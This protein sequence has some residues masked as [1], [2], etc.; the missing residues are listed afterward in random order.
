MRLGTVLTATDLNPLYCDFIPYFVDSW[1]VLFPEIDVV[2]VLVAD[3]IPDK[4]SAYAS[5]IRLF[6]PIEGLSTAFQ[7]QCIRLLYPRHIARDEGVMITDM[8]MIPMNR[9]Y[10][11]EPLRTIAD[12]CFVAFRNVLLPREIPMCYNVARP[13]VWTSVF[14][15][16]ADADELRS[17]YAGTGYDARHGGR[18]WNT[19]QLR[20][21]SK[22]NA[23]T[24][25]KI[26][27]NDAS[28]GFRR[29]D[30]M[31]RAFADTERLARDIISGAY[32]DYHCYRP[33]TEHRH[34]NDWVLCQL[35]TQA[36]DREG[37]KSEAATGGG[38]A[39]ESL[40][41][42]SAVPGVRATDVTARTTRT[43]LRVLVLVLASDNSPAYIGF[44]RAWT[45]YMSAYPEIDW[46]FYVGDP[47]QTEEVVESQ[48]R[49]SVKLRESVR[50]VYEK[51]LRV[52]SYLGSRL[53]TYDF[54]LRPNLSTFIFFDRYL[55]F[56]SSQ[57][58]H[59]AA[60]SV[61][62]MH[63]AIPYP[64][65]SCAAFTPDIL[66]RLANERPPEVVI[67]DISIGLALASWGVDV[68][69]IHRFNVTS[70]VYPPS[71]PLEATCVRIKGPDRLKDVEIFERLV[72][73]TA[74]ARAAHTAP[75]SDAS[76]GTR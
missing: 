57:P 37:I 25:P 55:A 59:R 9:D 35:R 50:T 18:G 4:Y 39:S 20:L 62:G 10:Y 31:S 63:G 68:T 36:K 8:D 15:D 13:C 47:S 14:G 70:S 53:T 19:D 22:F 16:V 24:G 5:Y 65:G 54:V 66:Q 58:R 75:L 11:I 61:V 26:M 71:I 41:T 1:R 7:A 34:V 74:R 72:D 12:D 64:S 38:A 48:N 6:A 17:W 23:W 2:V 60:C 45:R 46:F 33:Y 29:L 69:P 3:R 56:L 52:L 76:S 73:E 51:T 44:Q 67:D 43:A 40:Q 27:L 32:S 21:I 30:R 42:D 28:T 49:I